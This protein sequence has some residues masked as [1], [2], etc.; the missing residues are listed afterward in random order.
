VI[1]SVVEFAMDP[2][3]A[4]ECIDNRENQ[5]KGQPRTEWL[6]L[7]QCIHL[8][9]EPGSFFL[10]LIHQT[11]KLS[12]FCFQCFVEWRNFSSDVVECKSQG[13]YPGTALVLTDTAFVFLKRRTE[14]STHVMYLLD[15]FLR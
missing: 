12:E 6:S 11:K 2:R 5:K 7:F 15:R 8:K 10:P 13:S 3:Q 1:D 9:S 4:P 14:H